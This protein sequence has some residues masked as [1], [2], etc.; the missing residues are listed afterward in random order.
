MCD[1]GAY[2]NVEIYGVYCIQTMFSFVSTEGDDSV[3]LL[4]DRCAS[5]T[6]YDVDICLYLVGNG[7]STEKV[8]NLEL[9]S[10]VFRLISC[11]ALPSFCSG[12]CLAGCRVIALVTSAVYDQ[13]RVATIS[14]TSGPG[15]DSSCLGWDMLGSVVYKEAATGRHRTQLGR[16]GCWLH[17]YVCE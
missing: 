17:R 10:T 12:D 2:D 8:S 5:C 6:V 7:G 1:A 3:V 16:G 15:I 14:A 11:F 4:F 9:T 13:T